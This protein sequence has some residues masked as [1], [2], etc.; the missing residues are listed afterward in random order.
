MT[1]GELEISHRA[2]HD[3][4]PV[5]VQFLEEANAR[6]FGQCQGGTGG[7]PHLAHVDQVQ[8]AVLQDFRVQF[9]VAEKC[10]VH[11]TAQNRVGHTSNAGLPWKP[12][13]KAAFFD[14]VRHEIE[15]LFGNVLGGAIRRHKHGAAILL[16]MEQNGHHL[17]GIHFDKGFTDTVGGAIYGDGHSI[18]GIFGDENVMDPFQFRGFAVA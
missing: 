11:K 7:G 9:Q 8:D 3:F 5:A 6:F 17:F 14:F 13:G 15:N 2:K 16:I 4:F 18:G 12:V 1:S 10:V